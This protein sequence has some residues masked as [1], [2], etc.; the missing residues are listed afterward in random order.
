MGS[1]AAGGGGQ[2]RKVGIRRLDVRRM[3]GLFQ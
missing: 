2:R 3:L 1:S